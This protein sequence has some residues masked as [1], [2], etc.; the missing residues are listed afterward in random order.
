MSG[1]KILGLSTRWARRLLI[2]SLVV[3]FLIL[4]TVVGLGLR[5]GPPDRGGFGRFYG[6]IIDLVGDEDRREAV[7]AALRSGRDGWRESREKR[8]EVWLSVA[9]LLAHEPFDADAANAAFRSEV[10]DR[11]ERRGASR[12]SLVQ[13]F[14]IMTPP[15]RGAA[16]D[17]IRAF[18]EERREH[19]SR[20]HDGKRGG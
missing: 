7:R 9:D 18:V 12:E 15:E 8:N 6:E 16:A 14:L 19:E 11:A 4:G 13:A 10:D 3:N 17:R 5:H 1:E 20:R 2:A